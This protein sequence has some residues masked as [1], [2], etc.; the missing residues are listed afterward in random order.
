MMFA[1]F[2]A[3]KLTP[4]KFNIVPPQK[5]WLEDYTFLLG[6]ELLISQ[7]KKAQ[8]RQASACDRPVLWRKI[9]ESSIQFGLSHWEGGQPNL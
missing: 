7:A 3:S 4:P 1:K 2:S 5:R 6:R 9:M 8:E